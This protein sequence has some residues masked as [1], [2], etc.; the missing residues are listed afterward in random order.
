MGGRLPS[1]AR[2][3][4]DDS[5]GK[6]IGSGDC[7]MTP[8]RESPVSGPIHRLHLFDPI[9]RSP[10][11]FLWSVPLLPSFFLSGRSSIVRFDNVSPTSRGHIQYFGSR[12]HSML[13]P[14]NR[15]LMIFTSL[16]IERRLEMRPS[17]ACQHYAQSDANDCRYP[18]R[19]RI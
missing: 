15:S 13:Y 6:A 10:P 17:P 19:R 5:E 1:S 16:E 8:V 7:H 18:Q 9:V 11:R 4:V 2:R 12:F 14:R 3:M